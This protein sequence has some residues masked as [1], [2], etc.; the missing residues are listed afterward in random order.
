MTKDNIQAGYVAFNGYVFTEKDS[1]QYNEAF[2]ANENERH[3]LF[4]LIIGIGV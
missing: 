3:R 1:R 2:C 4:C